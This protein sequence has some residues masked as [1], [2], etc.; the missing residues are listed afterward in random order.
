MQH[1]ENR[2]LRNLWIII[3]E[4]NWSGGL[5]HGLYLPCI[6]PIFVSYGHKTWAEIVDNHKVFI[7]NFKNKLAKKM[8]M[9][10]RKR[11]SS[12]VSGNRKSD[13]GYRKSIRL[14]ILS[15]LLFSILSNLFPHYPY[16]RQTAAFSKASSLYMLVFCFSSNSQILVK[17]ASDHDLQCT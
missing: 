14:S 13:I 5:I 10:A 12:A 7:Y 16:K 17:V 3:K 11:Y 8:R 2:N 15:I 1:C 4:S 9:L 6:R